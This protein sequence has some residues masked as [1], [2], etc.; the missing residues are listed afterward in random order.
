[1]GKED[2]IEPELKNLKVSAEAHKAAKVAA[3]KAGV[4]LQDY[5]ASAIKGAAEERCK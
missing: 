5:V 2:S 4:S 1:M 3:A